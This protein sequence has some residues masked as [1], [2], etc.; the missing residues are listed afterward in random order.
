V[1]IARTRE[2]IRAARPLKATFHRAFDMACDLF[3]A[4]EDVCAAGA[5]R[6][7]TSGGEQT[8]LQ[9]V[10]TIANLVENARGRIIVMPGSGI[11]PDNACDIVKRTGAR[12]LHVGLRRRAPSPMIFRNP[13]ISMGSAEGVEYERFDVREEDVR[14]LRA[15]LAVD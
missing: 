7:L 12:E 13:R 15:A 14:S 10:E 5:D 3:R 9:G 6:I 8:A 1:D 4:I 11:N 2:L